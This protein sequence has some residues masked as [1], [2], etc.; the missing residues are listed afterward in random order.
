MIWLRDAL[1]SPF[2]HGLVITAAIL[3]FAAWMEAMQ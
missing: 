3:A 1:T 2:L